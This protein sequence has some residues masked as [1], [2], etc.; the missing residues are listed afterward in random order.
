MTT[1]LHEPALGA[2]TAPRILPAPRRG[3]WLGVAL[4]LLAA[5]WVLY[6]VRVNPGFQWEIVGRHMFSADVLRGVLM[7]L[8]LTALVMVMGT[9][10]GIGVAL[11]RL[12]RDPVL[13]FC[14]HA[15]VWFFRGTPV[16]V[17]LVFWYNLASLF[18]EISLGIPF[19]GPKFFE[20]SSTVAISSFTAAML[21]L[22]L[23]EAAYMAEIVRAGLLS[24]DPGQSEASKALG[25]RPWQTFRVVVLP[26]AMRAIVPPTGNQVIGMLKYTSIASVVALGE[27][28]HSVE[29]IYSRTFET[30]PLL[31]VAA[32]WYLIM[33]SILSALQHLIE[34]HY[35]RGAADA[36]PMA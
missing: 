8:Q 17:Q 18:P 5:A 26:Q 21:G 11:M 13:G 4:I 12:S 29:T 33:V 20:I 28:M 22:G 23:N 35:G 3:R 1:S 9:V 31:I 27:L 14:A 7:T 15:F 30:I 36:G 6:Q 10:I 2:A 32:L 16:L 24:V 25:H 19:G 34:R